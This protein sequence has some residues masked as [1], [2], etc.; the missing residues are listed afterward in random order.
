MSFSI[1]SYGFYP[2]MQSRFKI[3]YLKKMAGMDKISGGEYYIKDRKGYRFRVLSD[4]NENLIY[5]NSKKTCNFF[6]L[7]QLFDAGINDIYI[8]T[9][10]LEPQAVLP[11][12]E[13]YKKAILAITGGKISEY[14]KLKQS[15]EGS[16]VFSGYTRGHLLRELL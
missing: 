4:Y 13:S 10:S 12:I 2:V 16:S 15:L 1:F 9:T 11:V 3:D 7:P 6:D 14:E 5:L 8:D